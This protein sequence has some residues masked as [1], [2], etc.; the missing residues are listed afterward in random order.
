MFFFCSVLQSHGMSPFGDVSLV[1][2]RGRLISEG[3]RLVWVLRD[4]VLC[5][6]SNGLVW[7]VILAR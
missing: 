2:R 5:W 4:R 7:S 3:G 6:N 1:M